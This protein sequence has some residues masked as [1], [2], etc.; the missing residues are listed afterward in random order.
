MFA[1][2]A[3][4]EFQF[5]GAAVCKIKLLQNKQMLGFLSYAS[6]HFSY[7]TKLFLYFM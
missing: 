7:L 6:F 4:S 3:N 2:C 1:V 5:V